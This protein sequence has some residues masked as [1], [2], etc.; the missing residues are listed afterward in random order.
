[1]KNLFLALAFIVLAVP[2]KSQSNVS[3]EET[4][5]Y[6]NSILQNNTNDKFSVYHM[7]ADKYGNLRFYCSIGQ[8]WFNINDTIGIGENSFSFFNF[9]YGYQVKD[10]F[11]SPTQSTMGSTYTTSSTGKKGPTMATWGST[12]DGFGP[13]GYENERKLIK[14]FKHLKYLTK[15]NDPFKD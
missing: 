3:F 2:A 4:V 9:E 7:D 13:F 6:I 10:S 11:G 14:A 15:V 8:Y 5:R 1:M 12:I